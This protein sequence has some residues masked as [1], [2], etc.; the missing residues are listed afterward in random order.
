[1]TRPIHS[2]A[3]ARRRARRRLPRSVYDYIEGGTG[4]RTTL[5]DN[6]RAF[7]EIALWPRV[8]AEMGA[9]SLA[10]TVLGRTLSMPVIVSPAGFIRIAHPG[11]E[12]AAARAAAAAGTAIGISTLSSYAIEDICAAAP[13]VWYQLYFAGGRVAAE[14]A[15]DRARAAG[16]SALVLTMDTAASPN[17]ERG[18]RVRPVPTRVGLAEVLQYGPEMVRTPRWLLGFMRD[19]LSL[20]VPNVR[21]EPDGAPLSVGAASASMMGQGPAWSDLPWIRERWKGPLVV[22]SLL[23]PDDARRAVDEGADAIV[24]SNHGGNALDGAPPSIRALPAVVDAVGDATEVLLDSGIRRGSDV[25]RALALGARAVLVGRA[26]VWGLAAGG[27]KGVTE[28]L[29]VLRRELDATLALVGR[30]S[31]GELDP[32]VLV[33]PPRPS[34]GPT[35]PG[36]ER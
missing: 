3:E 1:V 21:T 4:G 17:R 6:A 11:G 16:C 9:R 5:R 27:E 14:L 2:V 19:G 29:E 35:G 10:T 20:N 31:V 24:V 12:L 18:H 34:A 23:H 22:K 36:T 30:R 25:V 28:V 33:D 26:Y 13:N 7:S 15:I 8:P 32:S